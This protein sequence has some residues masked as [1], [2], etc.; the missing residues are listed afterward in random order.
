MLLISANP[1]GRVEI[2][3]NRDSAV[4]SWDNDSAQADTSAGAGLAGQQGRGKCLPFVK[5]K[6]GIGSWA[7][8]LLSM[9]YS[10]SKLTRIEKCTVGS[11]S[12]PELA[13]ILINASAEELECILEINRKSLD[14]SKKLKEF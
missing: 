6:F 9:C 2:H 14:L 13:K 8:E 3:P 5:A 10:K 11:P 4:I 7:G 1:A 12:H